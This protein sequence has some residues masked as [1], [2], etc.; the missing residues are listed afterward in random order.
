MR[1]PGHTSPADLIRSVRGRPG[2]DRRAI[3]PTRISTEPRW[4]PRHDFR[5]GPSTDGSLVSRASGL[6]PEGSRDQYDGGRLGSVS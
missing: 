6:V 5:S 3:D 2:H 4:Y 1:L